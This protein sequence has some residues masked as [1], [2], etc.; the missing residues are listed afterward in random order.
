[1]PG[2]KGEV[3]V[4][5]VLTRGRPRGTGTCG[6]NGFSTLCSGEM[7]IAAASAAEAGAEAEAM[8]AAAMA[9]WC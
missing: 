8:T 2:G 7:A 3:V 4:V 1:M 9:A 5:G 6:G